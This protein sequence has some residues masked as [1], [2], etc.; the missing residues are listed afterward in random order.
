MNGGFSAADLFLVKSP[1]VLVEKVP[2]SSPWAASGAAVMSFRPSRNVGL[3]L[4]VPN[5]VRASKGQQ[6]SIPEKFPRAGTTLPRATASRLSS[7]KTSPLQ[8]A[9]SDSPLVVHFISLCRDI[10]L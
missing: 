7:N 6:G 5:L 9:G 10:S 1:I 2:I 3:G 8:A 4:T